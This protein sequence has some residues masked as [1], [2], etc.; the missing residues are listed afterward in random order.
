MVI[1]AVYSIEKLIYDNMKY[2]NYSN[3]P[4]NIQLVFIVHPNECSDKHI[5]ANLLSQLDPLYHDKALVLAPDNGNILEVVES[6]QKLLT[7]TSQLGS[8]CRLTAP[9][10]IDNA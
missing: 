5:R 2:L 3:N 1:L 9:G 7:K 4:N 8:F 6:C 10:N